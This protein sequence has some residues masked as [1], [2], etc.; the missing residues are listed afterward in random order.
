MLKRDAERR[1]QAAADEAA[2]HLQQAV[3][4]LVVLAR[5]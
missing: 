5:H 3:P 2:G 1:R 4:G